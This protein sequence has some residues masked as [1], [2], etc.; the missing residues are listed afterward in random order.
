MAVVTVGTRLGP[1]EIL[2]PLGAGGMGEVW[3]ARDHRLHRDVAVKVLPEVMAETQSAL[4][5]FEREARAVAA[6]SHPNILA[7]HDFGSD[8]GV[9]YAVMEL[10][11]GA[12]LRGRLRQSSLT[13]SRALE[14][15]HQIAQGLAAAHE[16]GII[17]RD[18]KPENIFVTRDG[19]VKILDFGLARL[20]EG[21]LSKRSEE[22]TLAQT[23]PG[24][25]IGTIGYLS[26]EQ[27]RGAT[28]DHRSDIF[29]FGV[30]FYEMLTGQAAFARTTAADSIVAILR[31]EPTSL[32]E[33]GKNVPAEVEDILAHCL[34]KDRDERFRSAGDLAFA[35]RLAI[36]AASGAGA[37]VLSRSTPR[38]SDSA[39]RAGENSIAVL[40]FRNIGPTVETEYFTDGMTEEIINSISNIPTL[41]V[42]ARTSS[43]AFKGREDDIRKIGRELGVAMVMEGS[44]R[45]VGSR[46]RVSAQL[47]NVESGYQV[48]SERW[49]RDL[50]DVFAVQ[51]EIAQAIAS[52]FK[53]GRVEPEGTSGSGK[54]HNVEAYDHYLKGRHLLTMRHAGEAIVEFQ[55]AIDRDADFVD[56]HTSLADGWA[57]RGFYGGIPTWEAWARAGA[58]VAEAERIAPDSAG[59]PLSRAILEH[60]YGWNTLRQEEYCRLAIERNPKSAEGWNWL[61]I[62]LGCLGRTR[63]ALEVTGRGIELEPYHVN[64]RTSSAQALIFTGDYETG[65]RVVAKGLE[66]DPTAAYA[67]W[68]RGIALR[69]LGRH[70]ESI[71]IF[72]RL[73]ESQRRLPFYVGLLGG[74][75]AAAGERSQ[76]EE[77]LNEL[78]THHQQNRGVASLD[79]ATVLSALGDDEAALDAL[80]R[81]YE[82]RNA[83]LW[84]RIYFPD[85]LRL[86]EHPR[87]KILAQRLGRAAPV[88]SAMRAR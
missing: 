88:V 47:I 48:W 13:L 25:V 72:E 81:A 63:E 59:V 38:P 85:H 53:L 23:R 58:A 34:E 27:A 74:S 22:S 29:S 64:V 10:L 31:E 67:L 18:L 6:L 19:V 65:E 79:T 49:D 36:R 35:L 37:E 80:E 56:A 17:H 86:R 32:V 50:A 60:Y 61:G 7:I 20:E 73:V 26:P 3:R 12:T 21:E 1:Y 14:W 41:H 45:Q 28:A 8:G 9:V 39:G 54:T 78:Q 77:I 30:V 84:S 42:A 43:F 15:A 33:C 11:E 71:T 4:A 55:S 46:L 69:F 44:V 24:A 5:R 82:E 16:R 62:C 57:I 68:T 51:D 52:T 76:A 66:L 75:L 40:P 70:G 2:T 87:W 83:L